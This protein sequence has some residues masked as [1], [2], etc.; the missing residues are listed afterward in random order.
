MNTGIIIFAHN[1]KD[2]DYALMSIIAGG[3][4]KKHLQVPV[5]LVT[6]L[7]TITWLKQSGKYQTALSVFD[8]IIEIAPPVTSNH[9]RLHDG[10]ESKIVPFV[11]SSRSDAWAVTP[12][13]RTLLIDSDYLIFTDV[14]SNYWN[15]S[16]NIMIS[17]GMIS[18]A[19]DRGGI[20][21]QWVVDEGVPMYWA[22]TVMFTKNKE[23]KLFFDLVSFIKQNY[24]TYSEIFKFNPTIFRNDI[25][26][27]I[28]KH[29]LNG[30]EI[31]KFNNLPLVLT[32]SDKDNIYSV[33]ESGVKLLINDNARATTVL[34]NIYDRDI[35]IMNKQSIIRH[36]DT[37]LGLI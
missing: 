19:G 25:A 9:R 8:K 20:L 5:S 12:Y 14:L 6:D 4:A 18:I 35:H 30:Y 34:A 37:F 24:H 23:S 16:S 32:S 33:S 11:N 1:S 26:F 13:D 22:T 29:I 31:D 2:L 3:L 36:A 15:C 21:D 7:P 10:V 27:G 17:P 28:A